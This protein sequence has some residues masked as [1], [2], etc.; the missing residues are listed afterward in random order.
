MLSEYKEERSNLTGRVREGF[1]EQV[2]F[3][4]GLEKI[5]YYLINTKHYKTIR[6]V[7]R[8]M[9]LSFQILMSSAHPLYHPTRSVLILGKRI[10]IL[11]R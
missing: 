3:D 2:V 10:Y 11:S 5:K 8:G 4:M 6:A 9:N 1:I 7:K